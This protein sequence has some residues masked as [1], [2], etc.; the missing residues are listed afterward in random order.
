M[1]LLSWEFVVLVAGLVVTYYWLPKIRGQLLL[2]ASLVFYLYRA[3]LANYVLVAYFMFVF[4]LL[5]WRKSLEGKGS[6]ASLLAIGGIALVPLLIS[7]YFDGR[8]PFAFEPVGVSFL[9]FMLL[10]F[11]FS[12]YAKGAEI[13]LKQIGE[14]LTYLFFLPHVVSGPI[15]NPRALIPQLGEKRKLQLANIGRGSWLILVGLFQKIVIG[16]HLSQ[17]VNSVYAQVEIYQGWPLLLAVIF[18]SFQLYCDFM[19]YSNIAL[20]IARLLGIEIAINF[21]RPYLAVSVGEFWRRW[22]IS[23]SNWLRDNIYFPL[24]GSRVSAARSYM[25]VLAVFLISGI[26][27]GDTL[28]FVL[29]GGLHGM[30]VSLE[31]LL[32]TSNWQNRL[33]VVGRILATYVFVSLTWVLFSFRTLPEALQVYRTLLTLETYQSG[34]VMVFGNL[35]LLIEMEIGLGLIALLVGYEL[36]AEY[37]PRVVEVLERNTIIKLLVLSAIIMGILFLGVFSIQSFYYVRF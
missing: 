16:N 8:L 21:R 31:R 33:L 24:G 37:A 5:V 27:H 26:W 20:G 11:I 35:D 34:L 4:A 18:F 2:I 13:K 9:S 28:A 30:A 22:H 29:W 10:S 14:Y 25:N 17:Y 32:K 7:K 36:L 19:G 12:D 6:R 1:L 15:D 23:L 3:S